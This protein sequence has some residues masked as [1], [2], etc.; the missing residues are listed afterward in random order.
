MAIPTLSVDA[1]RPRRATDLEDLVVWAIRNQMAHRDRVSLH[2]VEMGASWGLDSCLRVAQIGTVGTRIDGG[3][4]IRGVPP[5]MH[6]DA[7]AVMGAIHRAFGTL[8]GWRRVVVDHAMAGGRPE[9]NL[10][11]QRLWP[12]EN[13]AK[14]GG[15][16]RHRVDGEWE[17]VPALSHVARAMMARGIRII[18][19]R[20]RR[21]FHLAEP[22]Y[23]YR[24]LE[25]GTR[26]VF[27]RWTPLEL[28]PGDADIREA[29]EE[30]AEWHVG[31]MRVLGEL[32]EVPLRD[33]RLTGFTAPATPW[34]SEQDG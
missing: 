11:P 2:G 23:T 30:Y 27:V 33:H 20:G 8:Y 6:P 22:G 24:T 34:I 15:G 10:G 13:T 19:E 28:V 5:R 1:V 17:T 9:W 32:L 25:D 29:R 31:M 3:G 4:L 21:K 7:E 14:Q 18:D 16:R 12:V 26:E